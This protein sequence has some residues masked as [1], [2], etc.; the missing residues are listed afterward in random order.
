MNDADL[1]KYSPYCL[2]HQPEKIILSSFTI[3]GLSGYTRA[4]IFRL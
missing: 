3:V 2:A 4:S 1:P